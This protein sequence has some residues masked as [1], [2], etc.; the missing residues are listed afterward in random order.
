MTWVW[1]T[2]QYYTVL[3][4]DIT[5][6]YDYHNNIVCWL[7]IVHKLQN[8]VSNSYYNNSVWKLD[9]MENLIVCGSHDYSFHLDIKLS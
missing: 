3:R 7:E 2:I 5:S 9:F 4:L 1:I 8:H 6:F